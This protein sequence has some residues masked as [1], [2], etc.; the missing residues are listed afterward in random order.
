MG[1][2]TWL[3]A[4]DAGE[5]VRKRNVLSVTSLPVGMAE[6]R[7]LQHGN[8]GIPVKLNMPS[9]IAPFGSIP[10]RRPYSCG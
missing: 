1:K 10:Q 4:P 6:G 3:S 5:P 8:K 7:N 2:R 9:R